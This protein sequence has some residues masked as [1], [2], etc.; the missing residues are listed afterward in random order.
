MRRLIVFVFSLL[1]VISFGKVTVY[2]AETKSERI[3][4]SQA[5]YETFHAEKEKNFDG[6]KYLFSGQTVIPN[7]TSTFDIV[8]DNLKSKDY[9]A[10]TSAVNPNNQNQSGKLYDLTYKENITGGRTKNVSKS[11][12]YKA[13]PL[14]YTIPKFYRTE[15]F[16]EITD[17]KISADLH[18]KTTNNSSTYWIKANNLDG[19]VTS[20]NGLFY[21]LKNSNI[22]IPKNDENPIYKGYE[23]DILNSLNLSSDNYRII[24]SS[25]SSEP[26]YNSDGVLCRNCTYEAE[27]LACDITAEYE[28]EIDL[29]DATSYKAIATY[30][31]KINS[32]VE[33]ELTYEKAPINKTV[34]AISVTAGILILSML[35]ASILIILSKKK[36]SVSEESLNKV[37]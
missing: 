24:G 16:D 4:L 19:I 1:T 5:E 10:A 31:D 9:E 37:F 34:I 28:N 17:K 18:L 36:K 29:P 27:T 20:Y 21:S 35:I 2:A 11:V 30:I 7:N 15:Y 6:K 26:Y 8:I 13:V 32:T 12:S 14:N 22:F 25:W 33:L 3:I 23:T